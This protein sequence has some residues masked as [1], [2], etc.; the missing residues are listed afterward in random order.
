MRSPPPALAPLLLLLT[1]VPPAHAS[2]DGALAE[3]AEAQATDALAPAPPTRDY[4]IDPSRS[5]L[6]V[7]VR[8][9]RTALASRFAHDHAIA[10]TEYTGHVTWPANGSG[11]CRIAFDVPVHSLTPDPPGYRERAGLDPD[12]TVGPS[13]RRTIVENMLGPR[14]LDAANHP[15]VTFRASRCEPQGDQ[16]RVT[17]ELTIRGTTRTLSIPLQ[18]QADERILTA[19]GSF[20]VLHTDFGIRPF[21]NAAGLVRNADKLTFGLDL[22][23][24]PVD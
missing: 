18:V 2:D 4:R 3:R 22:K 8:T 7:T 14:Q 12:D 24:S 17:G 16:V 11:P 23:A 15:L 9:D 10:A 19:R 6:W 21:S 5:A 20:E 1:A 13:A